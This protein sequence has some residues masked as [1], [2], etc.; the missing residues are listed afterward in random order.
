MSHEQKNNAKGGKCS[1]YSDVRF[2]SRNT[3]KQLEHPVRNVGRS[4]VSQ[5]KLATKNELRSVRKTVMCKGE[6]FFPAGAVLS[7]LER[8]NANLGREAGA[9]SRAVRN[10]GSR[11]V[12]HGKDDWRRDEFRRDQGEEINR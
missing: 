3:P 12:V 6:L 10:G 1:V 7:N 11:L 2:R 9:G 8:A 5:S 4:R